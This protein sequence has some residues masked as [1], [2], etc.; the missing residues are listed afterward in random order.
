MKH[1]KSRTAPGPT[2]EREGPRGRRGRRRRP[3]ATSADRRDTRTLGAAVL[4]AVALSIAG[5]AL[6]TASPAPTSRPTLPPAGVAASSSHV[7]AAVP[8][9]G[10]TPTNLNGLVAPA[11]APEGMVWI[12]GGEFSMGA[13]E[14]PGMDDVGMKATTRLAADS[15]RLRRRL[16]DGHDRGDQRAVRGVRQGDGLRHRRRADAA[17]RGLSRRAA[18]RTWWPDRWSSRRPTMP[19]RSTITSSGGR[20]STARA[21]GIRSGPAAAIAGREQIP[22]RARRLRRRGGLR[23]VGGQASADRS[24]VGVRRA[25]RPER[26]ALS[27]GRRVHA[28]WPVAMANSHQGTFPQRRHRRRRLQGHRP[29]RAVRRRTA[30]A[31]TTWPATSG[32]GSSDWYRPD[33]YAQLAAAGGVAR[34]PRGPEA[35]FDPSEPATP[36]R[37]HRGGSFLCTDQYCS[38]YMVGTRGKGD[39]TRHESSRLPVGEVDDAAPEGPRTDKRLTVVA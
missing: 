15:S 2:E 12:P 31:S 4:A 27:V 34:N 3:P 8:A 38:R 29:G 9:A 26:Q 20:T 10:F 33:Y 37:V 21:G 39:A 5:W 1:P 35:S 25:R 7:P 11:D 14:P 13:A 18:A 24:R 23:E 6:Y 17:G 19:C 32:N 16:L 36:K 28:G 22:G 30:T